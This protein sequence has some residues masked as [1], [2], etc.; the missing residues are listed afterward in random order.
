MTA[1]LVIAP[2]T[3]EGV[4]T[5]DLIAIGSPLYNELLTFY[6]TEAALLDQLRLD[7]WTGLLAED[8]VYT[9]PIRVTRP[10][11]EYDKTVVRTMFHFEDDYG[12]LKL[13]VN[14]LT[15][16]TSAYAEDPPSRCRRFVSNLLAVTT[17]KPDELVVTTNLLVMRSRYDVDHYDQI[18]AERRDL[19]RRVGSGL[20]L[21]RREIILDQS[22]LG[23]PN[24]GIFL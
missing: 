2:A 19:V 13:R 14:R 12:S 10:L 7:D 11:R 8:M 21:A 24:L 18:T 17:G 9:A 16:T 15:K 1:S 4:Q 22:A 6:Y 3:A 20:K 23:M 5:K